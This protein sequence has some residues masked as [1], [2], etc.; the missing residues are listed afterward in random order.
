MKAIKSR[1]NFISNF[2]V[3]T[4]SFEYRVLANT[5]KVILYKPILYKNKIVLIYQSNMIKYSITN[6]Y[7]L[8]YHLQ[9]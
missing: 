2:W 6:D 5:L 8:L 9:L 3:V 7:S 1:R 4:I